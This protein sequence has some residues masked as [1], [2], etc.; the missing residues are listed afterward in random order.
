[1]RR[2]HLFA[3]ALG[4]AGVFL[5]ALAGN[6]QEKLGLAGPG[7]S[8]RLALLRSPEVQKALE[9]KE[10]Q[11]QRIARIRELTK[12][13]KRQVESAHGQGKEKRKT[14][15]VDPVAKEQERL[16]REAMNGDLVEVERETD[17]Q[18]SAVLDARQRARLTQIVLR[19]EGPSAFLTP[20]LID[21]LGLGPDQ[22]EAIREILDGMKGEQD[23]F[24]ESQK[25]SF[26]LVKAGGDFDLEKIRK[27]QQKAQTRAYAYR[28]SKQ[29]MTQIGRV[30]TRRQRDKYNRML[31]ESFDLGRLS[32]PQGQPLFDDSAELGGSLLRQPA[33]QAELKL[34]AQQRE[35]LARG[36]RAAKVLDSGQNARLRQIA[37]QGEG[38]AA[39]TRPEVAR[40]LRLDDEQIEQIE[41]IQGVLDELLGAHRQLRDTLKAAPPGFDGDDPAQVARRKEQEKSRLRAGATDI[42]DRAM[43]RIDAILTRRQREAVARLFGQRFDFIKVRSLP[44]EP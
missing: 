2:A 12:E 41:Q 35:R 22:V 39:L 29:V 24:K 43:Q 23:Q 8:L 9:L 3:V 10:E 25:R 40:A 11:N 1:M 17:R 37:L 20:E 31:G 33:V 21:A 19:V 18:I 7:D 26:E 4:A 44:P 32:G 16:A 13:A 42:R 38:P 14:K 34:T 28:L 5:L 6:G 15:A 30:L 36:E 27:D